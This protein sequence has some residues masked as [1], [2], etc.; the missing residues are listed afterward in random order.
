MSGDRPVRSRWWAALLGA[1]ALA[2]CIAGPALAG[3]L[4]G[5]VLWG[6]DLPDALALA[7]VLAGVCYALMTILRRHRRS[8]P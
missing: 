6:L 4:G 2:C 8:A 7:V 3:L 1:I 5:A